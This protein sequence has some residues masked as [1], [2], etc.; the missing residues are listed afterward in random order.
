MT[1]SEAAKGARITD[2]RPREKSGRPELTEAAIVVSGGRGTGG[3]FSQVEAFADALGA[4]VGASR[5]AV[6]A[7][8]Y[9]HAIPGRARPARPSRRSSTSPTA[10]PAPSSTGPACRRPRRSSPSTR[11]RRRRSSSSSTSASSATCRRSCRRPPRPSRRPRADADLDS[12]RDGLPRPRS[13]D[14]HGRRRRR[15]DV[16]TS[17][18]ASA[19][20][21]PCT[22]PDGVPAG[23]SR[24]PASCS[25]RRSAPARA[26]SCSPRGG[27]EADN[28][29]VKGGYWARRAADPRRRRV[30]ASAV[31]HHAVLDSV[32]WL[33]RPRRRRGRSGCRS[34]ATAGSTWTRCERPIADDPR[35]RRAGQRDVGQQRG[36]HDPAGR[37]RRRARPHAHGIPVHTDAVQAVGHVPVDFA[38][39]GLDLLTLTGH[40]LGGPMGVGALLARPR[41]RAGPVLHGG[42]QERD[43]RSRHAGRARRS[44]RSPSPPSSRSTSCRVERRGSRP[45]ATGWSAGPA[46]GARR[47]PARRPRP[48]PP[49]RATLNFAFPGL[50]GRLPALSAR[51]RRASSAPPARP[52]RRACRSPATCCWRWA[53]PTTWPA[54]SLRFSLGHTRPRPTST[55]SLARAARRGRAGPREPAC[56]SRVG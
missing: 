53:C 15:G 7:G 49:A 35:V 24:S 47:R 34:T 19:T 33:A 16:P 1:V 3:D 51:R 44:G 39:T 46:G 2:R 32:Q 30:L 21:R 27:T 56:A 29:A 9:P 43:V 4:A 13:D 41:R 5:A 20:P 10:S 40:K 50:R 31:E 6:D 11:T 37:R 28:L 52:A 25:R 26:R 12:R 55:R 23:S 36:R 42:G 45:C 14:A 38:A 17:S 22:R 8:W 48:E 54:A 18:H